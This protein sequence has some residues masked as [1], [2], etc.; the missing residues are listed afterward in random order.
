MIRLIAS[1]DIPKGTE[2]L[3][4]YG[5]SYWSRARSRTL[6]EER[7]KEAQAKLLAK[8]RGR[9]APAA[10]AAAAA[11]LPPMKAAP[12]MKIAAVE[13]LRR[14][15]MKFAAVEPPGRV[16]MK[17]GAPPLPAS[18]IRSGLVGIRRSA[19]IAR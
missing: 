9:L 11:P 3:V 10:P 18:K 5:A 13:P 8:H 19:R 17:I 6:H 16:R 7:V 4:G 1:K 12:P 2:I 14:P 15:R